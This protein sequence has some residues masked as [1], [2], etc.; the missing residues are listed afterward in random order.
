MGGN[1]FPSRKHEQKTKITQSRS[2]YDCSFRPPRH[3]PRFPPPLLS[4]SSA[5]GYS[6]THCQNVMLRCISPPQPPSSPPVTLISPFPFAG[7]AV[8]TL[9]PSRFLAVHSLFTWLPSSDLSDTSSSSTSL[10]LIFPN[11]HHPHPHFSSHTPSSPSS[12]PLISSPRTSDRRRESGTEMSVSVKEGCVVI[13]LL[14]HRF[15]LT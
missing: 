9:H 12:S 3:R 4:T 11:S 1:G 8:S 13:G 7:V 5:H 15:H 10:S 14:L 2:A 6:A